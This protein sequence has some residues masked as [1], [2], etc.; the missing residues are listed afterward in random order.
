M[1]EIKKWVESDSK[2]PLQFSGSQQLTKDIKIDISPREERRLKG[3]IMNKLPDVIAE[4]LESSVENHARPLLRAMKKPWLKA[5][6]HSEKNCR[7]FEKRLL[8]TWKTPLELMQVQLYLARSLGE[9]V[10]DE[11]RK[12]PEHP[13]FV[14]ID[15]ITR[16]HARACQIAAEVLVLL[17][18]GYAEGA[19]TRWRSLH[20]TTVTLLFIDQFGPATAERYLDHEVVESWKAAQEYAA[21]C[22]RLGYEKIPEEEMNQIQAHYDE[23]LK[24][25]SPDFRGQYGWAFQD[26]KGTLTKG[27]AVT[28]WD[29]EKG[30]GFGHYRPFYRMASHQV[31]A[32]PK[33]VKFKLSM[34]DGADDV[35]LTGPSNYG[36]ADPGQ[37]TGLS[38]SYV[39]AAIVSKAPNFDRL[40][41]VK[42]MSELAMEIGHAFVKVQR[43]IEERESRLKG[44]KD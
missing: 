33:A 1:R 7:G 30:V 40:L 16:L 17:R 6:L 22:E 34:M 2:G 36:L 11:M 39:T 12:H 20:E 3:A 19:M 5:A 43:R 10:N 25:H 37:N 27:R 42:V 14:L 32:N 13:N 18:T 23:M 24:K 26:I 35:L 9:E 38:L 21:H 44:R 4:L 41:H 8:Q 28:F 15:V 31:H 29:L